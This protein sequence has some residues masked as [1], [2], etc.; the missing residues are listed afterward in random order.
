V[1]QPDALSHF[2]SRLLEELWQGRPPAETQAALL[3][4]AS[5]KDFHDYIAGMEP[6]MLGVAAEL[7]RKWSVG[8]DSY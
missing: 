3:A 6:A 2:Q 5:L 7:V 8:T 1:P 4:D